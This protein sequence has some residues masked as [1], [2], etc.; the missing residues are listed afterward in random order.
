MFLKT[1]PVI[2][3][4]TVRNNHAN[5]LELKTE[6]FNIAA[7]VTDS[8]GSVYID[9]SQFKIEFLQVELVWDEDLKS[10]KIKTNQVISVTQCGSSSWNEVSTSSI[11]F[12]N[13]TCLKNKSFSLEGGY[14]EKNMKFLSVK[15]SYCSNETDNVLCRSQSEIDGFLKDKSLWVYYQANTYDSSNYANPLKGEW[16]LQAI[17]VTFASKTVDLYLKNLTF[18]TDDHFF[19]PA[20][21]YKHGVMLDQAENPGTFRMFETPLVSLNFFASKNQQTTRRV[22]EKL[23]E[24]LANLGGILNFLIICGYFLTTIEN[25]LRIRNYMINMLYSFSYDEKE[26]LKR[27]S[28]EVIK[29][30]SEPRIKEIDYQYDWNKYYD[31]VFSKDVASP[32]FPEKVFLKQNTNTSKF[33]VHFPNPPV[34]DSREIDPLSPISK[35]MT[36]SANMVRPKE[37]PRIFKTEGFRSSTV[38]KIEF[39]KIAAKNIMRSVT[40]NG[41]NDSQ[42]T[43]RLKSALKLHKDDLEQSVSVKNI[44]KAEKEKLTPVTLSMI[45][46]FHLKVKLVF[47]KKLSPKEKLFLVSDQKLQNETNVC[48]ILGKIREFEIFKKIILNASQTEIFDLLAKPIIFWDQVGGDKAFS[49]MNFSQD[50]NKFIELDQF[51]KNDSTNRINELKAYYRKYNQNDKLT[52]IDKNLLKMIEEQVFSI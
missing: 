13:Y 44:P 31:E 52:T 41:M 6:N 40:L 36:F 48:S 50:S 20:D 37:E 46:Y 26:D 27:K 21:D 12:S 2:R 33:S 15:I 25:E 17:P 11:G 7:A 30:K 42:D 8:F 14:D 16:F 5:L 35:T 34:S 28:R 23:G 24:L 9:P 38:A 47:K 4:Q 32:K 39:S 18:I 22:Y 1:N 3:D 49:K 43:P 45:E 29:N 19:F 10:K 51:L